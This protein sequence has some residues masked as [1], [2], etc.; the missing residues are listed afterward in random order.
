V[1]AQ[2]ALEHVVAKEVTAAGMRGE[3]HEAAMA[4]LLST[5]CT[6]SNIIVQE[7]RHNAAA[8]REAAIV[9]TGATT[10]NSAAAMEVSEKAAHDKA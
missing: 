3:R 9:A 2:Q 4:L 7:R 6:A 10:V 1:A 8:T 5:E